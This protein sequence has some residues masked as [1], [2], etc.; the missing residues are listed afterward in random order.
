MLIAGLVSVVLSCDSPFEPAPLT[1][2]HELTRADAW[3]L[4]QIMWANEACDMILT[5]GNLSMGLDSTFVMVLN[6]TLDCSRVG[7]EVSEQPDT[8]RGSYA[9]DRRRV[10]F[11]PI[12]D[13]AFEGRRTEDGVSIQMPDL[14]A[15]LVALSF[16]RLEAQRN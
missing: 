6:L 9:S 5:G 1:G 11:V 12:G 2:Q 4:P 14:A 3:P 13:E 10:M 8:I 7:S 15:R 16:R